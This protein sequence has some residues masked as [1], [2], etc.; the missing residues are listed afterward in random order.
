MRFFSFRFGAGV[1]P[2][3]I[4]KTSSEGKLKLLPLAYTR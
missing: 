2:Q 3:D 4:S 1:T